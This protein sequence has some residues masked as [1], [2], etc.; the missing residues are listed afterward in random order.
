M[1]LNKGYLR[2]SN[3]RVQGT[4]LARLR[5][6][7]IDSHSGFFKIVTS[8][9][10]EVEVPRFFA[11]IAILFDNG[12]FLSTRGNRMQ[13]LE[14]EIGSNIYRGV[15]L[16]KL[17]VE[18]LHILINRDLDVYPIRYVT[19][20][21]ETSVNLLSVIE[22][23]GCIYTPVPFASYNLTL[24]FFTSSAKG[25]KYAHNVEELKNA[26]SDTFRNGDTITSFGLCDA[27]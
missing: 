27:R 15:S 2:L 7:Y 18:S 14:S 21:Q 26:M 8:G 22:G 11:S 5:L 25:A 13:K 20:T 4:I 12:E 19:L 6:L 10:Q 1:L 9:T 16:R 3:V 17:T 24:A 23:K